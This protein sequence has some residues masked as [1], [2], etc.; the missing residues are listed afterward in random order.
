[1][2]FI[3]KAK[4]NSWK[5]EEDNKVVLLTKWIKG[6]E[7]LNFISEKKCQYLLDIV[8]VSLFKY[9]RI[10]VYL[11]LTSKHNIPNFCCICELLSIL[12]CRWADIVTDLNT[13]NPEY[14]DI[15]HLERGLQYRKTKKV[16]MLHIKAEVHVCPELAFIKHI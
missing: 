9:T 3:Y 4:T 13:Q 15:R 5:K 6:P 11:G 2:L 14:L 10:F 7:P 8:Q 12:L 16:R 1:M